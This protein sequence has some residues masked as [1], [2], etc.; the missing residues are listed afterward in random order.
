MTMMP[1]LDKNIT[2][3]LINIPTKAFKILAE[4][5]EKKH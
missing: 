1:K 3:S 4:N 2:I 5:S